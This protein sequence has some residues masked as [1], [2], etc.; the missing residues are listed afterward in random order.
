[1]IFFIIQTLLLL[2]VA[3]ILGCVAGC[4]MHRVYG[5]KNKPIFAG[6]ATP[7][8]TPAARPESAAIAATVPVSV[9]APEPVAFTASAAAPSP[10]TAAKTKSVAAPKKTATRPKTAA[11]IAPAQKD[12]L[13]LII[14]IGPQNEARLNAVGV[15]TFAQ[16][17]SWSKKD[18]ADYGDRLAFP[19]RIEREEWVKQAK[20]LAKG[21]TMAASKR[22][23]KAELVTAPVKAASAD[24]GKALKRLEKPRGGKSDNL[25]LIGGVGNALEKRLFG[26]GIFHFDQI[27]KLSDA[28]ASWLG[29][30]I[31]FPGRVQRENWRDEA[32]ILAAGGSTEHAKRVESGKIASS[33]KTTAPKKKT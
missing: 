32:K 15:M 8:A 30:E 21:G 10:A 2:A 33:H 5:V 22:S 3:Y 7:S 28:E 23:E 14:G 18:Q 19:G 9:P 6:A 16:I 11:I 20:V 17:A 27:A 26:L 24:M 13:K 1:M 25:T 31:G 12:D 4:W 29:A